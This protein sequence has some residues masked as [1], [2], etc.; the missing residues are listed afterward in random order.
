MKRIQLLSVLVALLSISFVSDAQFFK[1]TGL[2]LTATPTLNN[3][4]TQVL[5]RNSTTGNIEYK[6]DFDNSFW[7]TSGTT[8]ITTPTIVGNPNFQGRLGINVAPTSPFQINAAI[9][10]TNQSKTISANDVTTTDFVNAAHFNGSQAAARVSFTL[11]NNSSGDWANNHLQLSVHGPSA[12]NNYYLT[13]IPGKGSDAGF[14][15][16]NVQGTQITGMALNNFNATPLY[17]GTNNIARVTVTGT[18]GNVLIGSGVD[19]ARLFVSQAALTSTWMPAF[20][21]DPGAHTGITASTELHDVNYNLARTVQW[22]TGSLSTQRAFRIQAPTYSFV[23]ASTITDASTLYIDG[24]PIAGTNATITN[25]YALNVNSGSVRFGGVTQDDTK[26]RIAALDATTGRL[27]W[28]DASTLGGGTI[29]PSGQI[30]ISN[31]TS[32]VGDANLT[33]GSGLFQIG[34]QSIFTADNSATNSV[35]TTLALQHTT[36]GTPAVGIG[37]GLSFVAETAAGNNEIG[38]VIEAVTTD[39]TS[40]SEDF[41]LVTKTMTGGATAESLRLSSV[42]DLTLGAGISN[43]TRTILAGGTAARVELI[44]KATESSAPVE[45]IRLTRALDNPKILFPQTLSESFMSTTNVVGQHG[46]SLRINT[47]DVTGTNLNSG[48]ILISTGLPTGTGTAGKIT[49]NSP[50]GKIELISNNGIDIQG[51]VGSGAIATITAAATLSA[52]QCTILA[53][54]TTA[55]FTVTLPAASGATR[56]IY[57]ILKKDSSANA[58]TIS[59]TAGG[60]KVISTQYAGYVVQSDGTSWYV[61]GS[62]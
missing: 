36:S 51:S 22:A 16:L 15:L 9:A 30:A 49:L 4:Q 55:A 45:V 6:N 28:R 37:T 35:T 1:V 47:P 33:Y 32:L 12:P 60:N 43:T 19:N 54:A 7:K 23:G 26:T 25:P 34:G 38:A 42:G 39:V 44:L 46:G 31:G 5:V 8:N 29:I 2:T 14:A 50:S 62:F 20:R 53:D 48:N 40:L 21:V 52:S 17:L 24:A 61:I 56:R 3:T 11:S 59:T 41:D 13:N 27:F 18:L 57:R 58:V 10:G